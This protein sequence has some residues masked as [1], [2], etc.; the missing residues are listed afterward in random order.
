MHVVDTLQNGA[1]SISARTVEK[2]VVV[3]LIGHF[4]DIQSSHD[5]FNICVAFGMGKNFRFYSINKVCQ[6]LEKEKSIALPVF[7]S[8]TGCDTNF[9]L[10]RRRAKDC[11]ASMEMSSRN[12]QYIKENPFQPIE[13]TSTHFITLE[14]FTVVM[15]DKANSSGSVDNVRWDCFT[16]HNRALEHIP[17]TQVKYKSNFRV[18]SKIFCNFRLPWCNM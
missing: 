15:Y 7:H 1:K 8:Y 14:H 16:K 13:C 2:D 10:P 17:P 12:Y 4:H 18:F 3:L 5:C 9:L 6:N 11:L